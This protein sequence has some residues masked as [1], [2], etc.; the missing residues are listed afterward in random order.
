MTTKTITL[1]LTLDQLRILDAGLCLIDD[2]ADA[3]C[4]G[5]AMY[6]NESHAKEAMD[7]R[8]AVT[9]PAINQLSP[10]EIDF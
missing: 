8:N 1:T 4:E 3:R 9:A 10:G 6:P 5:L 7:L 2:V